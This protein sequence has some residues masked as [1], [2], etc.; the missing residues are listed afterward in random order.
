MVSCRAFDAKAQGTIF[1]RGAGIVV[2]KRLS[3]AIADRDCIHAVIKGSA[4]NNDGALKVGYTAPSVEGQSQV[5]AMAQ[6]LSD[7]PPDSISY[8]EAHG[9]GTKLGDPIE[10]EALTK[11]FRSGTDKTGFCGIGSVKTNIGHLDVAAGIAGFIK[12][13]LA[14]KHKELPPSLHFEQP[15]PNINFKDSPFYVVDHLQP[16]KSGGYPSPG[17]CQCLWHRRHECPCDPGRSADRNH[18]TSI[19]IIPAFAPLG[20]VSQRPCNYFRQP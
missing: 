17:R 7:T 13:L 15:N 14:L 8:I 5:I 16:W 2:L 9:T 18:G 20:K 10:V 19:K 4:I 3:E 1:G 6:A 11:A 12:T